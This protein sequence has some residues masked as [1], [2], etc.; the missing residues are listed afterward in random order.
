M[1]KYKLKN[2]SIVDTTDYDS[3]ELKY[4]L[5]SYPDAVLVSEDFQNGVAETDASAI[6]VNNQA[7]SGDSA[8]ENGSSELPKY[9]AYRIGGKE[10]SE[11]EFEG[12]VYADRPML[13]EDMWEIDGTKYYTSELESS[14]GDV[15]KYVSSLRRSRKHKIKFHKFEEINREDTAI[16]TDVTNELDEVVIKAERPDIIEYDNSQGGT[17]YISKENLESLEQDIEDVDIATN[18]I[19]DE[20]LLDESANKYFDLENL[21]NRD[22]TKKYGSAYDKDLTFIPVYETDE[23]YNDY[24]KERMGD[25][26]EDYLE[27]KEDPAEFGKKLLASGDRSVNDA[28]DQLKQG[29][30]ERAMRDYSEDRQDDMKALIDYNTPFKTPEQQKVFWEREKAN[31]DN[32]VQLI[33]AGKLKVQELDNQFLITERRTALENDL[34]VLQDKYYYGIDENA[35]PE[36]IDKYNSI[37]QQYKILQED[38]ASS[39]ILEAADRVNRFQDQFQGNL[40]NFAKKSEDINNLNITKSALDMD[41]RNST[42]VLASFE[43]LIGGGVEGLIGGLGDIAYN[44]GS[45]NYISLNPGTRL[46]LMKG[47]GLSDWALNSAEERSER[48]ARTVPKATTFSDVDKGASYGDLILETFSDNAASTAMS[49]L[50]VGAGL[51]AAKYGFRGLTGV[52]ARK[53]AV[54]AAGNLTSSTFFVSAFGNKYTEVGVL[55]R[56][57]Y[58]NIKG[59]KERLLMGD[60]GAIE[61]RSLQ[62]Q[63][64]RYQNAIDTSTAAKAFSAFTHGVIEFGAE[65]L[66]SLRFIESLQDTSSLIGINP[67]KAAY[68][69]GRKTAEGILIE[70]TEEVI[71]QLGQ[72][73]VDIVVLGENKSLIE[74]INPEF[75]LGTTLS[76]LAIS[77]PS[78]G[79]NLYNIVAD[80]VKT[81]KEVK[82]TRDL[83]SEY[84]QLQ[85]DKLNFKTNSAGR[86]K[87]LKRQ[88]EILKEASYQKALSISKLNALDAKGVEDLFQANTTIKQQERILQEAAASGLKPNNPVVIAALDKIEKLNEYRAE[89]LNTNERQVIE[90]LKQFNSKGQAELIYLETYARFQDQLLRLNVKKSTKIYQATTIEELQEQIKD[91]SEDK[92]KKIIENWEGGPATVLDGVIIINNAIRSE[93]I[94]LSAFKGGAFISGKFAAVVATHELLHLRTQEA[95]LLK[96]NDIKI[97]FQGA[98]MGLK[99]ILANKLET[100]DITVE[101]YEMLITRIDRYDKESKDTVDEKTGKVIEAKV[102]NPVEEI[103]NLYHDAVELGIVD[104]PG[105]SA[106][107]GIKS[108]LNSLGSKF[109]GDSWQFNE[110]NT[111]EDVL[112]YLKRFN[113]D[114]R[115]A[116]LNS[117]VA[118]PEEESKKSLGLGKSQKQLSDVKEKLKALGKDIT[119]A[120]AQRII[121][122]VLPEMARVQVDNR[123]NLSDTKAEDLAVDAVGRIYLANETN[124]WDG[125]GQLYGFLNGRIAKRILDAVRKNP[126]YLESID[127]NQFDALE[128]AANVIDDSFDDEAIAEAPTY[129]KL[130][131]SNVISKGSISDI[132]NDLITIVRVLKTRIDANQSLNAKIAPV[133]ADLKKSIGKS[134]IYDKII[135]TMGGLKNDQLK[136]FLIKNKQA[137]L[138]NMTT[139]WLMTAIPSA[140]KKQVDGKLTLDWAGK[141]IDREKTTTD[142]AGRTSGD[143]IVVRVKNMAEFDEA[144]FLSYIFENDGSLIRGRKESLGK[145]LAEE[146]GFEVL[147]NEVMTPNTPL[148][149]TLSE[150]QK[151]LGAITGEALVNDLVSKIERGN[152]KYSLGLPA[153]RTGLKDLM[154][155]ALEDSLRGVQ[156][157]RFNTLYEDSDPIIQKLW[158]DNLAITFAPNVGGFKDTLKKWSDKEIPKELKP[159]IDQY[160]EAYT[161]KDQKLSKTDPKAIKEYKKFAKKLVEILP[162]SLLDKIGGDIYGS[163]DRV[164][165]TKDGT[166]GRSL[167]EFVANKLETSEDLPYNVDHIELLQSGT[168]LMKEIET[169]ILFKDFPTAQAKYDAFVELYKDRVDNANAANKAALE[170]ILTSITNAVGLDITLLPGYIRYLESNTN[171]GRGMRALSGLKDIE[172]YAENQAPF[173]SKDRKQ[174]YRSLSK[175]LKEKYENNEITL[176]NFHPLIAEARAFAL[177]K[178]STDEFKI[179]S[180]LRNKGEHTNPSAN[181]SIDVLKEQLPLIALLHN[182]KN[183]IAKG[184]IISFSILKLQKLVADFDQQLNSKLLSDI[185]D[186]KL[187]STSTLGDLR[188]LSVDNK[189]GQGLL[190][191]Q[192]AITLAR[193]IEQ[194]NTLIDNIDIEGLVKVQTEEK[195]ISNGKKSLGLKGISVWDFDDTLATS[196]SM[197]GVTLPGKKTYKIDAEQF[198]KQSEALTKKGA[199]FDF[200]EFSKVMQGAKGPMFEKAIARNKK[201]GNSNVYILTARPANSA[202]AIHE[203]LKG[204]GLD[205]KLENIFG[206]ADG[207]P[208]AKADWVIS[209]VA[210]G[211]NDFYFADDVYKNVKAVQDALETFDVKGKVQQAR[212]AYSLGLSAGL[213]EMIERN[214]GVKAEARFSDIVARN[215]GANKGRFK[216]FISASA[217]DFRGLTQYTFAGKGKQGEIDQKFFEESLV[218]PYLQGVNA[219]E[220]ARQSLKNDYKALLKTYPNVKKRLGKMMPAGDYTWDQA[221]RVYLW[222]KAGYTIPGLS[223]RD[224]K[225]LVSQINKDSEFGPFAE[226][227]LLITKNDKWVKPGEYWNA[228]S[229]LSDLNNLSDQIQRKDFLSTFIENVDAMFTPANLNKIEALYGTQHRDALEN[230]I[231]RMKS[232]SNRP[233]SSGNKNEGLWLDW[234]NNSV[235]TIMFFNRRSALMQLLSTVNFV[236]WSD[237]NPAMAAMAFANQPQFWKDFVYIFNSDK[238]KQRRGGLKS[239]VQEQEIASAA[240]GAK[241]KPKAIISYLL[242][243]G[244]TPTQIADSF[245]ISAGGASF[246]RN[247]IKTYLKQGFS[248]EDAQTK[249]FEDFSS[250]SDETQQSGDPMLISSQQASVLGRLVLA[251]QNTPMQ[252]TRLMKKA[253]QDLINGRGDWKTNISKIAYYGAIQNFIFSALSNALFALVPGFDDED[254]TEEQ[255]LL[256]EEQKASRILQSMIDTILRGS[257]LTGAAV[258]TIKNTILEYYKQEEKGFTADHT[259]TVLQLSNVS[260]PIGSKLRKVYSA[261]QTYKFE[262]AVISER[263]FDVTIDGK[264]NLS[265]SWDVLGNLTSAG[266]NL[267][268][269][270]L[271]QEINGIAEALDARNTQWQ[272]IALALGWRTWGVNAKDEEEDIIKAISKYR[273]KEAGKVKAKETRERNK[274]TIRSLEKKL[275]PSQYRKYKTDTKGMS[276]SKRIE[277]LKKNK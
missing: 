232:G 277:Y 206:L 218:K 146:I 182:N 241:N 237:N 39:G 37:V 61:K 236:N 267:P 72:N 123:F 108:L 31:L 106:S 178:N 20:E 8:L 227:A 112:N 264:F 176:N 248:K 100:A 170:Y 122:Q 256:K 201:F 191:V 137:I 226:T 216:Y 197:I 14:M 198:A 78:M 272:R 196:K 41:Y 148:N 145:A 93:D 13:K 118:E 128:K 215:K 188:L 163:H 109:M 207:R 171:L 15:D 228:G 84:N 159:F 81:T 60:L 179:A 183:E 76:S 12:S 180:Y 117:G 127:S 155:L 161:F 205:I 65:K 254:E 224:Q 6:P 116:R 35:S 265:P 121:A 10:V 255:A 74:G 250:I 17:S 4:F 2:G 166:F 213:N 71:T 260:P 11:V 56:E 52:A 140:V 168:G 125:R 158:D 29:N 194:L 24:L 142:N 160:F 152:K 139:T 214:L 7:S 70:N 80:Q 86:R 87:I 133:I 58:A 220:Q 119:S 77:G 238:L 192:G 3:I 45:S 162:K 157:D 169:N 82:A 138:E 134:L 99:D 252:Y 57:A 257:G 49:L 253:G 113:Q 67:F 92:Q 193:G 103:I 90:Y 136:N 273:K 30:A 177:T 105:L 210:E 50:P 64:D 189:M 233:V 149:L 270:R 102:I 27:Y 5:G 202:K 219:I 79:Q 28:R 229:V 21:D 230:V 268:L 262:K 126:K 9:N 212:K 73:G 110:F 203:F 47:K 225:F 187:G 22:K 153:I 55:Q 274:N 16:G 247:R 240:R 190:D 1:P 184:T 217:D 132:K 223:K 144:T 75:F 96:N 154:Y 40:K 271:V 54:K 26:Y 83:V 115:A 211:Y 209:K 88:R 243:I 43:N 33:D 97:N 164:L 62:M 173:I 246:Y 261:I 276:I 48:L 258:S 175:P 165:G 234:I 129:V 208:Q 101:E 104:L 85:N 111:A 66:G 120:K 275:L 42:R 204:I 98:V 114:V 44:I 91:L 46:G 32:Q 221:V 19:T 231:K 51:S 242:K 95:G 181:F 266:L 200:G 244:F 124:K 263:G 222:S 107:F 235:G 63:I 186:E 135:S 245:A 69:V 34:K 185:Q 53:A 239:D 156:G 143:D 269:D 36:D 150:N 130:T 174:G 251:F 131:N 249:A 151:M 199:A 172:F 195:A 18:L 38:M 23:D 167:K 94:A 259:Y 68:R 141:K 25:R 59:L 89:L 147:A